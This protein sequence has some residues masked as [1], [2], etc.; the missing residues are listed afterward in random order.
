MHGL[1]A[2]EKKLKEL[3]DEIHAGAKEATTESVEAVY[4]DMRENVPRNSG[5]LRGAIG[6]RVSG[7][8]RGRV[9]IFGRKRAWWGALV[10]FGTSKTPAQPFAQPAA[11]A[12]KPRYPERLTRHIGKHLDNLTE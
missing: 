1:K 6:K 12:E 11:E 4:K 7:A 9:G 10:E 5:M 3:P 2:L 8:L